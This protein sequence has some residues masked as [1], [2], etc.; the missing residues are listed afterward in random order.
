MGGG[1]CLHIC[2]CCQQLGSILQNLMLTGEARRHG[3]NANQR[4]SCQLAPSSVQQIGGE[5]IIMFFCC[6]CCL[7][8]PSSTHTSPCTSPVR[9]PPELSFYT[10]NYSKQTDTPLF[11]HVLLGLARFDAPKHVHNF[12]SPSPVTGKSITSLTKKKIAVDE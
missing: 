7:F 3:D 6:C 1:V 5:N 4:R 9:K 10:H 12:D 2:L 11:L 8:L